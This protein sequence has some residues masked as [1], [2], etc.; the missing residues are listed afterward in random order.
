MKKNIPS[1]KI[2]LHGSSFGA[3]VALM[4]QY[5]SDDISA[6]SIVDTPFDFAT[7]VREELILSLIHI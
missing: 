5:A 3:M 2:G 7:L 4:A 6:L 1:D